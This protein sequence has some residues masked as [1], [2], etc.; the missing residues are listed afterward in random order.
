MPFLKQHK[1]CMHKIIFLNQMAGPLF[2]ELAEDLSQTWAPSLLYTGHPDTIRLGS[3]SDK[4]DVLKGPIHNRKNFFSRMISWLSY[5]FRSLILIGSGSKHSVLLIVSNPPFLGFWGA[6]FKLTRNQRYAILVYDIYPDLL[7]NTGRISNGLIAYVW[8]KLNRFVFKHADMLFTIGQDMAFRLEREMN[9]GNTKKRDG[10]V[11]VWPWADVEK[12][13]PMP[14]ENNYFAQKYGMIGK[15]IVLYSGNMGLTHDIEMIVRAAKHLESVKGLL[16]V[17]IGEGAKYSWLENLKS[18]EKMENILLLPFQPEHVLP[19]S[20]ASA[21]IGISAYEKGAE[22]CILPS[23]TFYYM[24][25][26]VAPLIISSIETDLT[27]IVESRECGLWVKSKDD[28]SLVESILELHNDPARLKRM[29]INAR[30]AAENNCSR[31]N[32][33]KFEHA[34]KKI[35]EQVIH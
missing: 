22:G 23:K 34:F 25:A 21:D 19:F 4:L 10:V 2:R 17:F 16:F 18:K 5:F 1:K 8:R 24:A 6:F 28:V 3:P 12:I 35:M 11:W 14:K 29:K 7:I 31:K 26:G 27:E 15:T 9:A 30:K 32:S 13:Q 20:M 33:A